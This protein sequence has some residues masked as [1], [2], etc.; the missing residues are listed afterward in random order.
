MYLAPRV[1]TA[2]IVSEMAAEA[3]VRHIVDLANA[4]IAMEDIAAVAARILVDGGHQGRA[5]ELTGPESLT[6]REK[7]RLIGMALGRELTYVDLPRDLAVEQFAQVMGE[8]AAWYGDGLQVLAEH[9]QAAVTTVSSLL[10]RPA[11][12]FLEWARAHAA[13]F[14]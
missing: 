9:P 2:A 7:V 6:R 4:P 10:G 5:Y 3:G 14:R 11:T 12:T 8:Y 1:D 13:L